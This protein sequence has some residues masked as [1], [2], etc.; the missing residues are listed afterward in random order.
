[1]KRMVTRDCVQILSVYVLDGDVKCAIE[2]LQRILED[3][4]TDGYKSV[5]LDWTEGT[6]DD[7][8]AFNVMGVRKET[9]K[10]FE[11]RVQA[12]KVRQKKEDERD[13]REYERLKKKLNK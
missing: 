11:K 7:S 5:E 10:E 9:D 2:R 4:K 12:E 3:A 13:Q 8:G 1:M 6:Y